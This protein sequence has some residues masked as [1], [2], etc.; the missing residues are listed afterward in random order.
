MRD[1]NEKALEIDTKKLPFSDKFTLA[2]ATL[3][4]VGF[5]P[6][7]PGTAASI[8]AV[9]IF[10]VFK[11][12]V[13]FAIFTAIA[14]LLSFMFC[15]RAETIFGQ[16]DCKKIVIDDFSGMCLALTFMPR[17]PT[18]VFIGFWL[19]RGFDMLKIPPADRIERLPGARGIVG[20]DLVAGLYASILLQLLKLTF[21][22]TS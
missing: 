14:I 19:F 9:A 13:P 16:K 1:K 15:T 5:T 20:D 22:I 18:L 10:W 12:Q 4:G 8:T 21:K 3:C 6:L 7:M 2:V 17:N 11:D